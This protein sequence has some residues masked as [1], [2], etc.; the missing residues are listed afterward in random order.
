MRGVTLGEVARSQKRMESALS[1]LSSQM[2]T[3]LAPVSVL[4]EQ[5]R[6]IND[7]LRATDGHVDELDKRVVAVQV[8]SGYIA[9][10]IAAGGVAINLFLGRHA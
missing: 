3:Q 9:G 1:T 5:I 10:I 2:Q 7:H 8:K 4:G 6:Q